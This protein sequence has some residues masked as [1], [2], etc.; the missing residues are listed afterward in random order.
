MSILSTSNSELSTSKR[1][2]MVCKAGTLI[3]RP[4]G[5]RLGEPEATTMCPKVKAAIDDMGGSFRHL[6]LDLS[7]VQAM[8]SYGLGL[9][10]ELRNHAKAQQAD[11]VLFGMCL[12][13]RELFR[14][15]KVDRLFTVA[16]T[17][18]QLAEI[19]GV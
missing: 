14:I 12:D 9:C 3:V 8:S 15:V 7:Y 16:L 19:V 2:S 13:I 4:T 6:V 10:I 17:P 18:M 5:P 1:F 11:A